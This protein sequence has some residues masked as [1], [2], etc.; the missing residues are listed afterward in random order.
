MKKIILPGICAL[1][2]SSSLFSQV[3]KD[4][5]LKRMA[6]ET[7]DEITKK[8]LANKTMDEIQ[9]EMGMAMIPI[10]TKYA[11]EL[12][13]TFGFSLEDQQGLE[14]VGKEIGMQLARDCPAF[15]KLII[16]NP[17]VLKEMKAGNNEKIVEYRHI[18]GTLIKI[19]PGDF[20]YLQ[21]RD[22]S[23]KVEKLWWMEYFDGSNS[24]TT[25]PQKRLNK[26]VKVSYVEKEIYNAA[27]KDYVK[28]KV[29]TSIE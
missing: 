23:G 20:S 5:L 29:I 4:S 7:C 16:N 14:S 15:L 12:Q 13:A 19:V 27:L 6:R 26:P 8:N 3:G 18:S 11:D 22:A 1:L 25:D 2:I 24:L 28:I 9:M 21:V 17:S 10:V